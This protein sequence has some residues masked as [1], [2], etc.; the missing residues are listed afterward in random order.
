MMIQRHNLAQTPGA[1]DDQALLIGLASNLFL[2]AVTLSLANQLAATADTRFIT[3]M[4]R[5]APPHLD[6]PDQTLAAL[7]TAG[8]DAATVSLCGAVWELQARARRE[9]EFPSG[10]HRF[11]RPAVNAYVGLQRLWQA[12]AEHGLAINTHILPNIAPSLAK[13]RLNMS[14]VKL[15]AVTQGDA[16]PTADEIA[17]VLP[18]WIRRRR[19]KRHAIALPVTVWA[20]D[21]REQGQALDISEGGALLMMR[22]ASVRGD[23]LQIEFPWRPLMAAIVQWRH[24]SRTGVKFVYPLNAD[25][26]LLLL[27][28]AKTPPY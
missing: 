5:C 2:T 3:A 28:A 10:P 18:I 4:A 26:P 24:D 21:R 6:Q 12:A 25:D 27:D 7:G 9:L 22:G 15:A 14:R 11:F 20:R 16:V 8:F 13:E 1:G 17:G 19:H 23:K